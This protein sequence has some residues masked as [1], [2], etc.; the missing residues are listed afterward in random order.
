ML[1]D[2]WWGEG[3]ERGKRMAVVFT[4]ISEERLEAGAG[5]GRG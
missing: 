2:K 3:E 4:C 5:V 1:K